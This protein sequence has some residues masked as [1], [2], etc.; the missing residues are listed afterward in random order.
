M[1]IL[2]IYLFI[3]ENISWIPELDPDEMEVLENLTEH[4]DR[5]DAFESDA[6]SEYSGH[7]TDSEQSEEDDF[8]YDDPENCL[9]GK[10]KTTI[11]HLNAPRQNVRR[12]RHNLVIHFPKVKN[13]AKHA[14][15]RLDCW[16]LFS[17]IL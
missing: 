11:W 2:F 12:R 13:L 15:N 5:V 6:E 7:L 1:F 3:L 8:E 4:E 17:L 9:L 16:S 14:K 10:E